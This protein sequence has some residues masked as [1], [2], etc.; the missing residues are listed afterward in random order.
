MKVIIY[1]AG[2]IG[3]VVGGLLAKTGQE[4]VLIGRP[5]HMQIIR[6]EG[7]QLITPAGTHIIRLPV[8][9]SIDQISLEF[10][11]LV[12]LCVKGQNTEKA[13]RELRRVSIVA[14]VFCL[15]NGVRNEEIAAR[16][17]SS[18]YGVVLGMSAVYIK[19]GEAR[20][21]RDPPGKM[22]IG[23]YPQGTDALVDAVADKLRTAG[24]LVE[25]TSDVMPHKWG[26]LV[27]NLS[28][29]VTAITDTIG[30][31]IDFIINAARKELRTLLDEANICYASVGE[32]VARERLAMRHSAGMQK[33]QALTSTWQSFA[34]GTGSA[35][36]EFLNGEVVRLAR[37]L[38]RQAPINEALLNI[39]QEMVISREPP[40]KYS[41]SELGRLLGLSAGIAELGN[42]YKE[43]V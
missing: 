27:I 10:D 23:C 21:L 31:E 11:D 42:N 16:Y 33:T 40:G 35:E 1:G 39:S 7:L 6:K 25:V 20:V 26:K 2:V 36:T 29:I 9:T 43:S 22:I 14:P 24:F 4:V 8:A 3:C 17:F 41:P 18:V 19:D 32:P 28:N 5:G 15:Q 12:F 30:S 38:G 34:R 13:L 37:K